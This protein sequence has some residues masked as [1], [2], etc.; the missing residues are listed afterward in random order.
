MRVDVYGLFNGVGGWGTH[1]RSFAV[2]LSREH[3]VR[4]VAWDRTSRSK[5][6]PHSDVP[7]AAPDPAADIAICVGPLDRTQDIAGRYRIAFFAWETTRIAAHHRAALACFDEIWVPS[8]WGR[9][10]LVA[11]GFAPDRIQVVPEGVDAGLFSPASQ[12]ANGPFRFLCV[13]KWEER[14]GIDGLV[15]CFGSTFAAEDDV[16]LLLHAHN[17]YLPGFDL[18][19]VVA[20]LDLERGKG[21]AIRA[22]MPL[23]TPALAELYRR[24]H[25]FV[26]PTR[27]EGWGLPILEAMASGLPTIATDYSATRDYL[28]ERN[29]FPIR[30]AAMIPV[31]DPYFYG[32]GEMLGDW[33]E[34]D[35]DHLSAIMRF[36]FENREVAR[37]R[38]KRARHDAATL[39]SWEN[40]AEIASRRLAACSLSR[41]T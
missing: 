1:G 35:W 39:W 33:A 3:S 32:A 25:A 30:V 13:G 8:R 9:D 2:A 10:V 34:P 40:A 41:A 5:H 18:K 36:V 31:H 4:A 7:L 20:E 21:P 37:E 16:E 19:R 27:A 29:G 12:P 11:N 38:G 22:S 17:P 24:C 6:L 14:K 23:E 26:L 15:R 28:N